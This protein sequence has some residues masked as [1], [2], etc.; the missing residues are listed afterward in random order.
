MRRHFALLV[1]VSRLEIWLDARVRKVLVLDKNLVNVLSV[2][3][4]FRLQLSKQCFVLAVS[5][6]V[7]LLRVE[8]FQSVFLALSAEVKTTLLCKG[9]WHRADKRRLRQHERPGIRLYRFLVGVG[10]L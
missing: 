8:R 6:A 9:F 5:S 3:L 4:P 7:I 2:A 1:I 10:C